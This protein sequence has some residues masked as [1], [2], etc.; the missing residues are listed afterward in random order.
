MTYA[1]AIG[2]TSLNHRRTGEYAFVAAL[3][4]GRCAQLIAQGFVNYDAAFREL[5][6]R[7]PER[8]QLCDWQ[9]SQLDAAERQDLY[10]YYVERTVADI[11]TRW[12]EQ[13]EQPA[14]CQNVMQHFATLT[15]GLADAEICRSFC[16][17]VLM[18]LYG[19]ADDAL[20]PTLPV[21]DGRARSNGKS[22]LVRRLPQQGCLASLMQRMLET[23]PVEPDWAD[24]SA[25]TSQMIRALNKEP[26]LLANVGDLEGVE[27]IEGVF[28]RCTRAY[29]IA[30]LKG[31]TGQVVFS[32]ELRN[33]ADGISID[34]ILVGELEVSHLFRRAGTSFNVELEHPIDTVIHL[35]RLMPR[36]SAGDFLTRIGQPRDAGMALTA[37]PA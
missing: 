22:G 12:G 3:G 16:Q 13:V 7:A 31:S 18:D 19:T 35:R 27:L 30:S 1:T 20:I 28:Y 26:G 4:A 17:S 33:D 37:Q 15:H 21:A 34:D 29:V 8:F 23:I 2:Q 14:F 36:V 32:L 9:G 5:T 24:I 6:R 11:E 25:S 10:A